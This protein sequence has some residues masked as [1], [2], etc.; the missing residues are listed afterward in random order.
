MDLLTQKAQILLKLS[1]L[2]RIS[3][4]PITRVSLDFC[5]LFI[6]STRNLGR[7][8]DCVTGERL[9]VFVVFGCPTFCSFVL[10]RAPISV[11]DNCFYPSGCSL[12]WVV[13]QGGKGEG[14]LLKPSQSDSSTWDLNQNGRRTDN[15]V[16]EAVLSQMVN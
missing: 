8:V 14:V 10:A 1:F 16:H 11:L 5:Q 3:I 4:L 7:Q 12:S 2:P 15:I 13:N 6:H 9:G